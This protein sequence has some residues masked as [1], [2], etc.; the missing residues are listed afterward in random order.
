MRAPFAPSRG[1]RPADLDTSRP[2][3][4]RGAGTWA[5][6]S[7]FYHTQRTR[8]RAAEARGS[9][10]GLG[11]PLPGAAWEA[12]ERLSLVAA[13]AGLGIPASASVR[14]Q[15]TFLKAPS[16]SLALP[17]LP[18]AVSAF[19]DP[20]IDG[21]CELFRRTEPRG[22]RCGRRSG[23]A[24]TDFPFRP[25]AGGQACGGGAC[26][27]SSRARSRITCC[28]R[29]DSVTLAVTWARGA[30]SAASGGTAGPHGRRAPPPQRWACSLWAL[31]PEPPS[32][33][34]AA[35]AALG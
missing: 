4:G 31:E 5:A 35:A 17:H 34:A 16:G 6:G 30:A 27:A 20:Q 32:A 26:G 9:R 1:T 13:P 12:G 25:Q 21:T 14:L 7:Q 11:H 3:T 18:Q 2:S 29:P 22:P 19:S 28:R 8:D 23:P 24:R 10:P 15:A 33:A